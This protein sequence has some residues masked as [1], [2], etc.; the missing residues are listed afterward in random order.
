MLPTP[1]GGSQ[2]PGGDRVWERFFRPPSLTLAPLPPAPPH[3]LPAVIYLW[4]RHHFFGDLLDPPQA[5]AVPLTWLPL[6]VYQ[7]LP[8]LL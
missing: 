4:P 8:L 1:G 7:E 3:G 6:P 5:G 2:G